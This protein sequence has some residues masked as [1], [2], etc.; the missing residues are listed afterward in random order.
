M[1][2]GRQTDQTS[3][4]SVAGPGHESV[5]CAP[6]DAGGLVCCVWRTTGGT[7]GAGDDN[8]EKTWW[9]SKSSYVYYIYTH[10]FNID[11]CRRRIIMQHVEVRHQAWIWLLIIQT[12]YYYKY[13][14]TLI[15]AGMQNR[16]RPRIASPFR[17]LAQYCRVRNPCG[18]S[19]SFL[20]LR[21]QCRGFDWDF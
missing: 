8:E 13:I 18:H 3:S 19:K 11:R 1:I 17:S 2:W 12:I 10:Y 9:N 4:A 16:S 7:W 6:A 14:Y 20:Q 21:L 15:F 5:W